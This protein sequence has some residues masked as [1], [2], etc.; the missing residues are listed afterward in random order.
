MTG[1]DGLGS[2]TESECP[3]I[4]ADSLGGD[5]AF[6]LGLS[7]F[8]P[9]P[10]RPQWPVKL[11]SFIN[12]GKVVGWHGGTYCTRR[13]AQSMA[14]NGSCEPLADRSF[15]ENIGSLYRS[16]DLSVGLGLLYR[17]DPLRIEVNFSL[18]LIGRKGEGWAR[19]LG[20]GIG[21]EFL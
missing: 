8:A 6:A 3:Y 11:H 12:T 19:G 20:V 21:L 18:P 5:L 13:M 4:A 1:V 7:F 10:Y 15:G 16:P 9:L 17:L 2:G 14:A